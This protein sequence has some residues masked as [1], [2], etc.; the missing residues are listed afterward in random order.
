[1]CIDKEYTVENR[2]TIYDNSNF[3]T[4]VSNLKAVT[5]NDLF[6]LK[7]VIPYITTKHSIKT[8]RI[9][10]GNNMN[11]QDLPNR[12]NLQVENIIVF[13]DEYGNYIQ[14]ENYGRESIILK[15]I[16][17]NDRKDPL[18]RFKYLLQS[19]EN[20]LMDFCYFIPPLYIRFNGK[21]IIGPNNGKDEFQR[22]LNFFQEEFGFTVIFMDEEPQT[23]LLARPHRYKAIVKM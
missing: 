11:L 22:N 2:T 12:S 8:T 10:D 6:K 13:Q 16:V 18:N 17:I 21:V 4:A 3:K 9:F 5:E 7:Y 14:L 1:M 15:Y 23:A 19:V 20:F